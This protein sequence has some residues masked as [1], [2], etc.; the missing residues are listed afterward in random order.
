MITRQWTKTLFLTTLIAGIW[1]CYYQIGYAQII[2]P[3]A[4]NGFNP[5]INPNLN[6]NINPYVPNNP[7]V[8]P[9]MNGF[10]WNQPMPFNGNP[11]LAAQAQY[12]MNPYWNYSPIVSQFNYNRNPWLFY[13]NANMWNSPYA[14]PYFN[15][16]APGVGTNPF[17]PWYGGAQN[18]I[19][20]QN[21]MLQRQNINNQLRNNLIQNQLQNNQ[22]AIRV[23]PR[24]APQRVRNAPQRRQPHRP[25]PRVADILK[26]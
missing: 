26:K 6:P 1:V 12:G 14:N 13:G 11:W 23:I 17:V 4:N 24:N 21:M 10:G 5:N 25:Q 20:L 15:P 2:N 9:R 22:P 7:F 18:N 16:S 8:D 3:I 19:G